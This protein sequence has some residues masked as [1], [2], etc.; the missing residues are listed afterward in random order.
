V[1]LRRQYGFLEYY[2]REFQI[3]FWVVV[4]TIV[5][6]RPFLSWVVFKSGCLFYCGC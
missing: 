1:R 6:S 5:K 2:F 4:T 3:G